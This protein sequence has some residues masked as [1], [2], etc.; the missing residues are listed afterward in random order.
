LLRLRDGLVAIVLFRWLNDR[1]SPNRATSS[2]TFYAIRHAKTVFHDV[3]NYPVSPEENATIS[4][5]REHND[6]FKDG[7]QI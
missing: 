5:A 3:L 2:N 4:P 7:K 1:I 6:R